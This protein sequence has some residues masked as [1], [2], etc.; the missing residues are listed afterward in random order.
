MFAD[1]IVVNPFGDRLQ[2]GPGAAV[3]VLVAFLVSFL[4]I[5]TSARLTRSV[6]WWPGGI[7]TEGGV[8][9]H[10]LVFGICLMLFCGFLAFAAPLASPWW[11][12]VAIG[13]GVGAGFTLDEFALWVRLED[14]YWSQDGRSSFDAVVC[15]CAFAALV[16]IGTRPFGL[17]E[18]TSIV[19]TAIA[20]AVVLGLAAA[21]F[22]KGRVLLGVVGLFIP[23]SALAGA[24]RLARPGSAWATWHYDPAKTA[25]A[26]ARFAD[27]RPLARA[28]R[29]L[30]D[31]VAGAPG[32]EGA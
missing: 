23:I 17:D 15:S 5:R 19:G 26:Q 3:V 11:H 2:P 16:V 32:K 30:G 8:H 12:L 28:N 22:A 29:R 25:R 4:A 13:F 21:C 14:V 24:V 10:H 9:I 1:L 31:L 20:V 6:S 18:P 7:E 27:T